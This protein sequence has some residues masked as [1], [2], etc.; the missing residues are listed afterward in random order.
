MKH[1]SDRLPEPS[2]YSAQCS[3]KATGSIIMQ[4]ELEA[5]NR[6]EAETRAF[7]NCIIVGGKK[8]SVRVS[9]KKIKKI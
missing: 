8:D 6:A 5:I 4:K 9:V 7:L 3:D 2:K 1:F